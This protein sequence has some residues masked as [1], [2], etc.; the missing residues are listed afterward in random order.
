MSINYIYIK[1]I[2]MKKSVYIPDELAQR[3]K[4]F[5]EHINYSNIFQRALRREILKTEARIRGLSN[6]EDLE[7]LTEDDQEAA[8]YFYERGKEWGQLWIERDDALV[9][10]QRDKYMAKI[11]EK[12]ANQT[13]WDLLNE[14]HK[15][16]AH[17]YFGLPYE[18][19][20]DKQAWARGFLKAI[21]EFSQ[22]EHR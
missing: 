15:E 4:K 3:A 10:S 22:I 1:V 13:W 8:F 14:R 5:E 21:R 16:E 12:G 9:D 2:I 18:E 19:V 7:R 17:E 11:A 20:F 6:K